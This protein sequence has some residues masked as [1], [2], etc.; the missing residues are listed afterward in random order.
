[1][2]NPFLF[3]ILFFFIVVSID[4]IAYKGFKNIFRFDKQYTN[5]IYWSLSTILTLGFPAFLFFVIKTKNIALWYYGFMFGTLFILFFLPKLNMVIFSLTGHFMNLFTKQAIQPV[6]LKI[7]FVCALLS[8]TFILYGV[9]WGR[10][11]YQI[12]H[13]IIETP[14]IESTFRIVHISDLHLGSLYNQQK[15]LNRAIKKIN[16]QDPDIVV[17]SG[18]IVNHF[19][20]ETIGW[21]NIIGKIK[22]RKGKFAV[23]GNHDYGDYIQWDSANEKK[24]NQKRI[25]EFLIQTG[26]RL[27]MN[28]HELVISG[29]D[30]LAI[31]GVENTGKLPFPNYG[32]LNKA[33]NNVKE[34]MLPILISHD[35]SHWESEVWNYPEIFLTLSGHTHAMQMGIN[36]G[37]FS[38]SPVS[39]IYKHWG[40][41]YKKNYQ[42]LYVNR[43]LGY[44]GF[45]GRIGMRPEITVI[46]IE[47][48]K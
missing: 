36:L 47:A 4:L 7:G 44:I 31:I 30:T 11:H 1:M 40:G 6:F 28:E 46:D 23:L 37:R 39:F 15:K 26:F 48:K 35:P 2:K 25:N 29:T 24:E 20:E 10:F 14:K 3:V 42:Y 22:A 19:S 16:E 34:N 8:F 43:G 38:F 21:E 33:I 9:I 45:L 13:H 18:D 12:T 27:L 41:L 17:F 5:I 32:N